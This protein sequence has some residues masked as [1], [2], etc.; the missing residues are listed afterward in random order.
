MHQLFTRVMLYWINAKKLNPNPTLNPHFE[1]I[2]IKKRLNKWIFYL[3]EH[4]TLMIILINT[5]KVISFT[6]RR[7][8][9]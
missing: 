3:M 5:R 9:S 8:V 6:E 7:K 4:S 1:D 2:A